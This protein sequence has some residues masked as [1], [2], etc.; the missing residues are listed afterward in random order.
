MMRQPAV[1]DRGYF[2]RRRYTVNFKRAAEP[3]GL[4]FGE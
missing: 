2:V 4:P 1:L 3:T